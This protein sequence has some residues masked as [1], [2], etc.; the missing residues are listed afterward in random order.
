MLS[1][2]FTEI[3][4]LR[5]PFFHPEIFEQVTPDILIT[6]NVERYLASCQPDE[7]RPSFFM[8]PYLTGLHTDQQNSF[9][10][11]LPC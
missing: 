2:Y 8:Y 5:T 6:Q 1:Y 7:V 11:H 10:K 9:R 4:F 3:L